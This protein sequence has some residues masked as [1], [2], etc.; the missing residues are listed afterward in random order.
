MA[1]K[2]NPAAAH[3]KPLWVG[4]GACWKR[5]LHYVDKLPTATLYAF[6]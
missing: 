3:D 6:L 1:V 5:M 4:A 2:M